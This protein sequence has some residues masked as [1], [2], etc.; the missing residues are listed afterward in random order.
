MSAKTTLMYLIY[1]L[2]DRSVGARSGAPEAPIRTFIVNGNLSIPDNLVLTSAYPRA[3]EHS[4]RLWEQG[5]LVPRAL[6]P[7]FGGGKPGKSALGTR[8]GAGIKIQ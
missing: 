3:P 5:N 1:I 8:L 7:G 4:Y 2:A 6:F